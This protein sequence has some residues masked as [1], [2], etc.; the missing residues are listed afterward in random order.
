[1]EEKADDADCCGDFCCCEGE[2]E[3]ITDEPNP[4]SKSIALDDDAA[5]DC[6]ID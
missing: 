1:M 3:D 2:G 6:L 5:V 4:P